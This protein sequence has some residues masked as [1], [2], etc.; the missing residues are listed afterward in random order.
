MSYKAG[1]PLDLERE[2]TKAIA[3]WVTDFRLKSPAD[4]GAKLVPIE[5]VQGFVPS[6]YAGAESVEKAP[7]IAVRITGVEYERLRGNATLS[8]MIL[9]WDDDLSRNGYQDTFNLANHIIYNLQLEPRIS[10]FAGTD[11]R[12]KMVE[13]VDPMRDFFPYFVAG[14]EAHYWVPSA[15]PWI[16][17]ASGPVGRL[18]GGTE[19]WDEVPSSP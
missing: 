5:V 11:D 16:V 6:Y 2:A 9:T 7:A 8:V 19:G 17:P 15:T 18:E 14:V 4:R 12:I 10:D 13:V 1:T 3:S